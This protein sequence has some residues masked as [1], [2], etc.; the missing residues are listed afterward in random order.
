MALTATLSLEEG[1]AV[2]LYDRISAFNSVYRHTFLP[3]LA[4]NVP[5]LVPYVSNL[6]AKTSIFSALYGGVLEL[7]EFARGVKQY[8]SRASFF[9][10]A[11]SLK[12]L[13]EFI[14]ELTDAGCERSFVNLHHQSNSSTGALPHHGSHRNIY[15]MATR[16][17]GY[18][19]HLSE[20]EKITGPVSE[21]SRA[22]TPHRRPTRGDG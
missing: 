13:K 17:P 1:C 3:E 20:Q 5:P 18:R 12:I 21:W 19:T 8:C 15:R 9:H 22:K 6:H 10:S 4:E 7:V 2:L 14:A 11:V 16:A